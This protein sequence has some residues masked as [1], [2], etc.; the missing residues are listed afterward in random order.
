MKLIIAISL[1]TLTACSTWTPMRDCRKG[2]YVNLETGEQEEDLKDQW[3][4]K[5]TWKIWQ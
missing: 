1:L 4:C 2:N 3:A 5:H